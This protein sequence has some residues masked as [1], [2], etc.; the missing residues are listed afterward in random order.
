MTRVNCVDPTEL[1]NPHLIV[2]VKEITRIYRL[3]WKAYKRGDSPENM[4]STYR[5]GKGHVRFFY[6]RLGYINERHKALCD[7]MARR[8]FIISLKKRHPW[9]RVIDGEIV[10]LD[11][12]PKKWKKNWVPTPK[13]ILINRDRLRESMGRI[14][15]WYRK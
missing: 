5:L 8:K 4:P 7:E 3:A 2:E 11:S 12:F 10:T 14:D 9:A 6:S 1:T 15:S 13:E